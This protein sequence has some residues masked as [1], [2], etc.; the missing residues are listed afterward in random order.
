MSWVNHLLKN[1]RNQ[2]CV[3]ADMECTVARE[4]VRRI[5]LDELGDPE[6]AEYMTKIVVFR[7][8]SSEKEADIHERI[9]RNLRARVNEPY[10]GYDKK[11]DLIE[12]VGSIA[13]R[14]AT[15]DEGLVQVENITGKTMCKSTF[16]RYKHIIQAREYVSKK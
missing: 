14:G 6:L 15:L 7:Y 5:A 16:K 10:F 9:R 13:K 2:A 1:H 3:K 8:Y 4:V 12:I 11:A